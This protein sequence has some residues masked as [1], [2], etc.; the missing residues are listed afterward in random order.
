MN[1][2]TETRHPAVAGQFYPGSS[3]RLRQA[4]NEYLSLSNEGIEGSPRALIVPHAG[5]Q[6]SGPTA[7]KAYACLRQLSSIERVI[8]LAPSHRVPFNGISVGSF[9]AYKTPLGRIEVDTAACAQL[10]NASSV[11]QPFQEAQEGEHALEVQL[12]FLQSAVSNF[13]LVPLVCGQLHSS[14]MGEAASVLASI[15]AAG[16]DTLWIISSDFTHYGASFGYVP[17]TENIPER[18]EELDKGAIEHIRNFDYQGF[19]EYLERTG[20]TVCGAV[21]ISLFLRT[22]ETADWRLHCELADYSTSGRLTHDYSHTVSYA[23]IIFIESTEK[24]EKYDLNDREKETLLRTARA[25]ITNDLHADSA[26]APSQDELTDRL[27]ESGACFVTLRKSGNLRGCIGTLEARQPLYKDVMDNARN[28]AFRD[29]RFPPLASEELPAVTI[30]IS[31][32]T[33]AKTV[34]NPEEFQPG[35]H[36]IILEK[37]SARAVFLPQVAEEQGWDRETTLDHLAL[38]A[39]LRPGDWRRN[40]TFYVFEAI[41]FSEEE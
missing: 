27:K 29:P 4:L 7:G 14:A 17:F 23:S 6:F 22:V 37:G 28:A 9:A 16:E 39:G 41:V 35:K 10:L 8:V 19:D 24:E 18:I 32:L 13:R 30:E 31:V 15:F 34:D 2:F 20:A 36:G 40:T 21:P 3:E 5:Y 25:T 38:K 33:P 11:F 1:N 26:F 12:P